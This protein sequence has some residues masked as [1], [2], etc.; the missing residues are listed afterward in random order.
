MDNA[1]FHKSDKTRHIIEQNG[2]QLLFLPAYS[3][4]LNPI[5]QY[6]AIIK[7]KIKKCISDYSDLYSCIEFVFQTI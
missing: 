7:A 5:E 6:W 3:P 1:S 2:H 4:D